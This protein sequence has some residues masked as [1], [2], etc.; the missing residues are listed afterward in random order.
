MA[1][2]IF[3][4]SGLPSDQMLQSMFRSLRMHY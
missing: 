2:T 1:T 4:A 3:A